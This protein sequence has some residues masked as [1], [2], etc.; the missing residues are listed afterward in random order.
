MSASPSRSRSDS[1]RP[2]A[3]GARA[4]VDAR[5][6]RLPDLKGLSLSVFGF[7]FVRAWDDV[8]F[9][10]LSQLVP[11]QGWIGQDL[12]LLAMIVTFALSALLARRIAPLHEKRGVLPVATALLVL[13]TL[14]TSLAFD[15]GI[16][17]TATDAPFPTTQAHPVLF[18]VLATT[19]IASAGVGA[20]LSILL[21]AELQSCFNSF[22]LVLYVAGAFFLGALLGWL[23]VGLDSG[24]LTLC[25]TILPFMSALCLRRGFSQVLAADLPK[26]SWGTTS[27]P[28]LLVAVVGIYQLIFGMTHDTKILAVNP[29]V[30]G[31]LAASALLFLTA[32]LFSHAFDLTR[33]YR[34][35]FVLM[36]CGLLVTLLSFSTSGVV[37]SL[38]VS[39]AY[40][41][42]FLIL[43]VLFCDISHRSGVSVLVLCGVQEVATATIIIGDLVRSGMHAG[44]IPLEPD[45][46]AVVVVLTVLVIVVTLALIHSR[47]ASQAWDLAFFGAD[48]V[49]P[50]ELARQRL[51]ER[52]ESVAEL[53]GLSPREREV[54]SLIAL[55]K[56]GPQIERELCIAN[57]TLKSHTQRI[58]QKLDVH[59]RAEL[60]ALVDAPDIEKADTI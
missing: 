15:T 43:T 40:N 32:Y 59:S 33:I 16:P 7:A 20:A 11:G 29:A 8:A 28:W 35:P 39:V 37:G 48:S 30:W 45:S 57:G 10:R 49:S 36:T 17:G 58:Y 2:G 53:R 42:M 1:A 9:E 44:I 27:F 4:L 14:A 41:S 24:R 51:L 47:R 12:F 60:L 34:T 23:L 25:T 38:L 5:T 13:S 6:P 19:A 54:L 52:C 18:G 3:R 22:R 21:W 26:H 50:E 31:M 46:T 56:T 55:G